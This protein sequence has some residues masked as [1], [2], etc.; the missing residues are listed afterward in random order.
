MNILVILAGVA[1]FCLVM[2]DFCQHLPPEQIPHLRRWFKIWML[3]G[4]VTPFLLWMIFN[5]A[6][7]N[8][9]PP[10]MPSVEFAKMNGTWLETLQRVATLGLFVIGTYWAALT[11]GWLLVVLSRQTT[12]PRQFRNCLLIWSA[13]LGPLAVLL[14]WSFGWRF[15]GLGATLWLAARTENGAHLFPRHRRHQ[16]RQIRGGG[17]SRHPRVGIL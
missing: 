10:L 13:I 6:V 7:L 4:L 17:E 11:V 9:L 3:K 16:L 1:G 14:T 12:E 5:S 8:W 15:A 2:W